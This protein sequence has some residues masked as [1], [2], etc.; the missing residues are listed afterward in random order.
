[1]LILNKYH[2]FFIVFKYQAVHN[3]SQKTKPVNKISTIYKTKHIDK[4]STI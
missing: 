4:I 3:K 1:M 2:K